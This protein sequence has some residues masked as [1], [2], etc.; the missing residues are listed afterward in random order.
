MLSVAELRLGGN[1]AAMAMVSLGKTDPDS[2]G[3]RLTPP[4]RA[5]EDLRLNGSI[6]RCTARTNPIG[7]PGSLRR[8]EGPTAVAATAGRSSGEV[9]SQHVII[10][11]ANKSGLLATPF[12][13][14]GRCQS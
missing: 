7:I 12:R 6:V 5:S 9:G 2:R 3:V 11:C 14:D 1:A 13:N 8:T 10:F 4:A